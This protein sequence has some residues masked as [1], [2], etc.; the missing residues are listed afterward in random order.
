MSLSRILRLMVVCTSLAAGCSSAKKIDVGGTCVLNSDCNQGLM[1]TWGK[2]HV[3][4]QTSADCQ[5]GQSCIMA[6]TQSTVCESPT[7]CIYNSDCPAGLKCAVDQQCRQ[8]CQTDVD[9][10][11]GQ[12]CTTTLTCADL[13]QVDPNNNLV[14]HDGGISGTGGTS[15]TDGPGSCSAGTETCSCYPND[16]CNAGL[17]CASHLCVSMGAGGSGGGGDAGAGTG[18]TGGMQTGGVL[19]TGGT[20]S[21]GGT[22]TTHG[23]TATGGASGAT[24]S[25]PGNGGPTMVLLPLGYCIDS[26]EVTQG[27]YETWLNTNPSPSNQISVCSGNTSFTPASNWPPTSSTQNNPVVDVNWCDAYAYCAGVGKRLCG[28]IG[29][30]SISRGDSTN[31]ALSQWYAACT[32]NGTYSSTGYPYGNT[33]QAGYCNDNS[34]AAVAV[35][36]MPRCQSTIS[37]YTGVYDLSGNVWEWEDLCDSTTGESDICYVRGGAFDVCSGCGYL[38]CGYISSG[39]RNTLPGSTVGFRCCS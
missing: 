27:Q 12:A 30:G 29:G 14:V 26:T 18:A 1:C 33:Y 16:T 38:E 34:T 28:K 7:A 39:R 8:Q 11:P 24:A 21:K 10:S 35:G 31:A 32:S 2:C 23:A 20:T 36:T 37:G 6:S 17:T 9:C 15:G 19:P 4:C 22:T 25:C 5:P 3:A 13:N